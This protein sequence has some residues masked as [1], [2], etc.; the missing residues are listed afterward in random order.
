MKKDLYNNEEVFVIPFSYTENINNGFTLDLK[1][2]KNIWSKYDSIGKYIPRS[3]TEGNKEAQQLIPYIFIQSD[4]LK[5][6]VFQVNKPGKKEFKNTMT[7]GVCTHI[8]YE[9]GLKEPLFKAAMRCILES[10]DLQVLRPIE[11][12][13]YVRE[14]N[15]NSNDHLG[16]VF[17][18]SDIP[19]NSIAV[20]TPEFVGK[21]M[22]K[23]ELI[24]HYGKF[25]DWSK[26][27]IDFMVD[28]TL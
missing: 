20:K 10:V 9:D 24:E 21:W 4:T 5:Y 16:M 23:K 15:G 6:F 2:K 11:F 22:T 28:N 19:E 12:R 17:K 18:I 8:E 3:V 26:H 25:E 7:L 14:M 1:D 27:L 13:G